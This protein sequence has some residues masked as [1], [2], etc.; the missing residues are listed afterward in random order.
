MFFKVKSTF[1]LKAWEAERRSSTHG[2]G[3][4]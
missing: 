2:P 4:D 3:T 1:A